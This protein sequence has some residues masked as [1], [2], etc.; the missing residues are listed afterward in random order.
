[1]KITKRRTGYTIRC[2]PSEFEM[3][4]KLLGATPP[5]AARRML[6][7][8]AKNAHSRRLKKTN[9]DLLAVD[10]DISDRPLAGSAGRL[11]AA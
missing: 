6:S 10:N 1:M 4:D 2:N 3:L 11:K 9:G 8:N 7:G 5:D